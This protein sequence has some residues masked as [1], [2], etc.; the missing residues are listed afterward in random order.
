MLQTCVNQKER[1]KKNENKKEL[2]EVPQSIENKMADAQLVGGVPPVPL[3]VVATVAFALRPARALSG[4]LDYQSKEGRQLYTEGTK[5]L[6][7]E[8][9]DA[10]PEELYTFL[11]SLARRAKGYG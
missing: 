2:A 7:E 4:I 1:W 6:E 5:K 8:L 11:K 3:A 9:F 10:S